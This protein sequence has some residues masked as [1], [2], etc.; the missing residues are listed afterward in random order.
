MAQGLAEPCPTEVTVE[1]DSDRV[2]LVW[3]EAVSEY[4]NTVELS[5]K[6]R[7]WLTQANS[8]SDVVAF[9]VQ[10]QIAANPTGSE[11]YSQKMFLAAVLSAGT[12]NEIVSKVPVPKGGSISAV[13]NHVATFLR[14]ASAIDVFLD[15]LGNTTFA[16]PFVF[17]AVRV[18]L[19]VAVK[20]IKLL[21]AIREKFADFEL[22]LRRLDVYL[23]LKEP[24]EA[25]K[26][27][28]VRVLVNT[29]RFCGLATRYFS[30]MI[31]TDS[32]R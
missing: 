19:D 7:E 12:H 4:I 1:R 28:T 26:L 18:M 8:S 31:L 9:A 3:N 24:S 29:L 32:S 2:S 21:L 22:R 27:M 14:Y 16:S 10:T 30:S 15:S 25:I 11:K 5:K 13:A 20:N 6:D 23:A 17:G